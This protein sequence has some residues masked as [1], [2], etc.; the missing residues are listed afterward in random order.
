[1][2]KSPNRFVDRNPKPKPESVGDLFSKS[3]RLDASHYDSIRW[4]KSRFS[5]LILLIFAALGFI[6]IPHFGFSASF[7]LVIA[8]PDW[9]VQIQP[10]NLTLSLS[11]ELSLAASKPWTQPHRLKHGLKASLIASNSTS[12]S[13]TQPQ[14][15]ERGL[16][17]SLK[18]TNSSVTA[19]WSCC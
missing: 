4:K 10:R 13:L 9:W 2:L 17:L 8:C 19:S 1:M 12:S 7:F 18:S 3:F 14:S 11:L 15:L 6:K 5:G 16:K